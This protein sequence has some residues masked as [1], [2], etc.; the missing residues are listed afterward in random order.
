MADVLVKD[1]ATGEYKPATVDEANLKDSYL[2]GHVYFRHPEQQI[3]VTAPDGS[4]GLI[5]AKHAAKAFRN[6]YEPISHEEYQKAAL[7]KEYGGPTG[8]AVAFAEG[9]P[10]GVA[11]P[12]SDIAAI[13]AGRAAGGETYAEKVR[14]HLAGYKEA[15]PIAAGIGEGVGFIGGLFAGGESAEANLAER[16]AGEGVSKEAAEQIA[17]QAA[18][19]GL[20]PAAEAV[21]SGG[22]A[23]D[24]AKATD[25]AADVE[26]T[27]GGAIPQPPSPP[28]AGQLPS[29]E[30]APQT[31]IAPPSATGVS[32]PTAIPEPT[33]PG[34]GEYVTPAND[35]G[36][37]SAVS[38]T[39]EAPKP[40]IDPGFSQAQTAHTVA[41][42]H[43]PESALEAT[44]KLAQPELPVIGPDG[45][46]IPA[47]DLLEAPT[48]PPGVASPLTS[49]ERGVAAPKDIPSA[50][51]H[52]AFR[53]MEMVPGSAAFVSRAGRVA[54]GAVE[55]LFG[56]EIAQSA[57]G[58]V[59]ANAVK[60]GVSGAVENGIL[61]VGNELTEEEL[62]DEQINAQKLLYS[63][64]HG[65][66]MGA[67]F[68]SALGGG[69]TLAREAS[70]KMLSR[71]A[72]K[73]SELARVQAAYRF[74]Q[75]GRSDVARTILRE[76][77]TGG[78]AEIGDVAFRYD[79]PLAGSTE[80]LYNATVN[81][82]KG[83]GAAVGELVPGHLSIDI[84]GKV[85]K[86]AEA[87]GDESISGQML[88]EMRTNRER[89][90]N[91]AGPSTEEMN[92]ASER[93]EY[94]KTKLKP[95][96]NERR[97][98]KTKLDEHY[99][100]LKGEQSERDAA[101][102]DYMKAR[103]EW[104]AVKHEIA[105][106]ERIINQIGKW[107]ENSLLNKELNYLRRASADKGQTIT[108][109]DL[110]NRRMFL[111]DMVTKWTRD[112]MGA[113]DSGQQLIYKH[114]SRVYEKAI[115]DAASEKMGGEWVKAYGGLK[116]DY[117][118]MALLRKGIE[119]T[120]VAEVKNHGVS[121]TGKLIALSVGHASIPAA[122]GLTL[123]H[124]WA[125][126]RG[127]GAAAL[128]FD[129]MAQFSLIQKAAAQADRTVA[130]GT[131]A[132]IKRMSRGVTEKSLNATS[133]MS[134]AEKISARQNATE[135]LKKIQALA[136]VPQV[137]KDQVAAALGGTITHAPKTASALASRANAVSQY[138][139]SKLP[140]GYDS[141]GDITGS[142]NMRVSDAELREFTN[143]VEGATDLKAT[144]A[145]LK[146]GQITP[147]H[148]EAIK[149]AAPDIHAM[150]VGNIIKHVAEMTPEERRRIPM[151]S[152]MELSII[153]GQPVSWATH[154]STIKMFQA[155][156][157]SI[158]QSDGRPANGAQAPG[159][160]A[161][162][163]FKN[164]LGK[165]MAA[166]TESISK[167]Q[168]GPR[169]GDSE[170]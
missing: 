139:L 24:A 143:R 29:G 96:E 30:V 95:L 146:A 52:S 89:N 45:K 81:T 126:E 3:A 66:L 61:T 112:P 8:A 99:K 77:G 128:V 123:A 26:R 160:P 166:D 109:A 44:Q 159:R 12:V 27:A 92:D 129:K 5:A 149:T 67:A 83:I 60:Y 36:I 136:N 104:H 170:S 13:G 46:E 50:A 102:R 62:G 113:P 135:V 118:E 39:A 168:I 1:K 125:R 11:G 150:I 86:E 17:G 28:V 88:D 55:E 49:A 127:S 19:K 2:A 33:R 78:F 119:A 144:M 93:S 15:N 14:K 157:V 80:E 37:P 10:R 134:A 148:I 138:L 79:L 43:Q 72:P 151:Q 91:L 165:S 69:G 70:R 163:R 85:R 133:A 56:K 141:L 53:I 31:G 40:P 32:P 137:A 38:V 18:E 16:A 87:I 82:H 100:F 71:F 103:D 73:L 106:N 47:G 74:M 65:A 130:K 167:P 42:L 6:G 22:T 156:D 7:E 153:T 142:H 132:V 25:A 131:N 114:L 155:Q 98:I 117:H 94:I 63:F 58:K 140:K 121:L 41:G 147:D 20:T 21:I 110:R 57:T 111:D 54:E 108:V 34:W 124:K 120:L 68:G 122:I 164:S 51:K 64:G 84:E 101:L 169:T 115:V 9:I 48:P 4:M 35:N 162:S 76:R 75:G 116:K 23:A 152:Q 59:L 105:E 145:K 154:P 161:P 90:G 97:I 158:T 107:Q